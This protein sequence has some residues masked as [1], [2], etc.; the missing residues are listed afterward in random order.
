[1]ELDWLED[2]LAL[3]ASGSFSR[4]AEQRHVTQPAF[5]RRIRALEDWV[6]APLID[7]SAQPA[8]L[9][10]A[11]R[12]F[13]PAAEEI[14]RRLAT[15]RDEART[16]EEVAAATLRFAATHALSLS[17][18]P[19]WLRE[20]EPRLRLGPIQ[21]VSDSLQACEE[22]MRQ[23]RAQFLL[24]HH[25]PQAASR[26]DPAVFL[27]VRT[28]ADT[29]VPVA[30]ADGTG[31][32]RF[33]LPG[34]RG[35]TL[36]VLAYHEASGLGRI[37]RAVHGTASDGARLEAV[38]TSHLAVVLK[39]MVLDGRGVA[40]LPLSLIGEELGDGRLVQAGDGWSV[41]VEIRMVRRR[42]PET[43]AAEAFWRVAGAEDVEP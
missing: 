20:L 6:G 32:P 14:L 9:T 42:A 35:G 38:F 34:A 16:A 13:R 39:R 2:F 19:A 1:V 37:L 24:C 23:G 21:L 31:R 15:A 30:A 43:P 3:S 41:P 10:E 25:H 29:L 7:R 18:F 27:S 8:S 33:A 17:F 11:G 12:R 40:W 22:L 26:L 5:S 28:G 4:A 36:P